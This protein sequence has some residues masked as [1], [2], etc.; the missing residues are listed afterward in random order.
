MLGFQNKLNL[1][2]LDK[3]NQIKLNLGNLNQI[4]CKEFEKF[5]KIN[6]RQLSK[7]NMTFFLDECKIYV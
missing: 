6:S 5:K 4:N 2:N 1:S 7:Q 3:L